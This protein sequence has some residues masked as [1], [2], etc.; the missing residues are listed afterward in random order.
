MP[1]PD[2]LARR[3]SALYAA[4][5]P[6]AVDVEVMTIHKAK[7]LEFDVVLVPALERRASADSRAMLAWSEAATPL[8]PRLLLAPLPPPEGEQDAP[9]NAFVRGV[10]RDKLRLELARVLYVACTRAREALHL[11]ADVAWSERQ[12][13]PLS[14]SPDSL[15]AALWPVVRDRFKGPAEP[16]SPSPVAAGARAFRR[17]P[18]GWQ[19][20]AV[21]VPAI[22]QQAAVFRHATEVEF[23]WAGE[24]ARHVGTVA[25]D[26]LRQI[27]EQAAEGRDPDHLG[28]G[29]A[30]WRERLASLGVPEDEREAAV[31][32]VG[33]AVR[34][35][36][37][38]P[39]G[40]WLL[41]PGHRHARSE[42]AVSGVLDGVLV[43]AVLD[44][45]FVDADGVR[46]IV[47]YKTGSHGGGGMEEFL[48]R[49]QDRYREQLERYARLLAG[50]ESR[51]TRLGL[52]FPS[53]GGWREWAWPPD[54]G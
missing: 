6:G 12:E 14:P 24:T 13:G 8:G 22:P 54:G 26:V 52:Y 15:L 30:R 50:M 45:T 16:P 32:A 28:D 53:I 18:G 36:L 31:A 11:Y 23:S 10:E 38:D 48:D 44:R 2:E 49:E 43:N 19:P 1:D 20:P 47:D 34:G 37:A 9:L 33:S 35:T 27:A 4:P 42:Y 40:R 5:R 39:R 41:E 3:A 7:G 29:E 25:H 21:A 51:P 17:L 46:W